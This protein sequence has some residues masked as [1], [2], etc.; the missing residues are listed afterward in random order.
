[1]LERSEAQRRADAL[2][3]LF[4]R[5]ASADPA[6]KSPDPVVNIVVDQAVYEAQLAAMVG[7]R[8]AVFDGSDLAH[9]RCQTTGGVPVDPADAV[10]A[11][12]IG[13]RPAG[14]DRR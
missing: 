8:R 3:A 9:Q 10:V 6:A 4:E 5:A 13:Q 14:R 7:D 11:S 1:M 2:A 12:I